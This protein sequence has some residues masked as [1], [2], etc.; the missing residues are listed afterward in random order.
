MKRFLLSVVLA[1]LTAVGLLAQEAWTPPEPGKYETQGTYIVQVNVDGAK[2][3]AGV[4]IGAFIDG[5]CRGVATTNSN[6]LAMVE[7]KGNSTQTPSDNG[8]EVIFYVRYNSKEFELKETQTWSEET[9]G[10]MASPIV[11]DIYDIK[12]VTIPEK[13]VLENGK[14]MELLSQMSFNYGSGKSMKYPELPFNVAIEIEDAPDDY[15]EIDY[16]TEETSDIL[17]AIKFTAKA[18]TT[19]SG[20]NFSVWNSAT[21]SSNTVNLVIY[22]AITAIAFVDENIFIDKSDKTTVELDLMQQLQFTMGTIT[23]V[24]ASE[25]PVDGIEITWSLPTESSDYLTIS[26]NKLIAKKGTNQQKFNL[27]ATLKSNSTVKA[28][29]NVEVYVALKSIT[30][31]P[32][33]VQV[34]L[35]ETVELAVTIA[36]TD[37]TYVP[38]QVYCTVTPLVEQDLMVANASLSADGKKIVV[39]GLNLGKFTTVVEKMSLDA[40]A[41]MSEFAGEVGAVYDYAAGWNWISL[42]SVTTAMKTPE[43]LNTTAFNSKIVDLRS[44]E[45]ST[46]ND[47]SYGFFG[48][49][50]EVTNQAYR[51]KTSAATRTVVY[52]GDRGAFGK[53]LTSSAPI[54]SQNLYAGWTW[55]YYPYAVKVDVDGL[56]DLMAE[57]ATWADG[58]KI[59]SKNGSVEW[60]TD[61]FVGS[62]F[63][64]EPGASYLVYR[65]SAGE[66]KWVPECQV[67]PYYEPATPMGSRSRSEKIFEYDIHA[68][69]SNMVIVARLENNTPVELGAYVGNECRGEGRMVEVDG[70]TYYFITVQGQ[71]GEEVSFKAYDGYELSN[72]ETRVQ[73][74]GMMGNLSEPVMLSGL[75]ATGIEVL[76]TEST[77]V[78]AYDM[79]GQAI[80]A[81]HA[82]GIHILGGEKKIIF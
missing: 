35:G 62:A 52:G 21:M 44:Q 7:V 65:K 20:V 26:S 43:G 59:I 25:L 2:A 29:A 48:S 14:T 12:S 27:T 61:K 53:A 56:N 54:A 75:D 16:V 13:M 71:A 40:P 82:K 77:D 64:L 73:F 79:N 24:S 41:K 31:S 32:S 69:A 10:T 3:S 1:V 15:V 63:L 11:L 28:T 58:D 60:K 18:V 51:V 67:N 5:L 22:D 4:T 34:P 80:H 38:D 36:P 78:Q 33:T 66:L 57:N 74:T 42:P 8:K 37:A 45:Q 46:F 50:T 55:L 23:N 6:G 68:Y 19:A 30:V 39:E 70:V 47:P 72:L 17:T 9:H 76:T 81:Q 49:L